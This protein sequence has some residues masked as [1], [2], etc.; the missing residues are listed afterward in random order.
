MGWFKDKG[1]DPEH[2]APAEI[3]LG[4]RKAFEVE[5]V[6]GAL[7]DDGYRAYLVDQGRGGRD[8]AMG[9]RH[10]RVLVDAENEAYVRAQFAEAGML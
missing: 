7:N 6:V 2:P 9:N 3:D 5:M 10:C 4:M 8:P 1:E